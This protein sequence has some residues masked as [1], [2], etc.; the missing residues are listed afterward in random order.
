M[1]DLWI[2]RQKS[3]FDKMLGLA[4]TGRANPNAGSEQDQQVDET[5][6]KV[7]YQYAPLTTKTNSRVL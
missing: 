2:M 5:F 3:A 4:S 1:R 6:F 7:R